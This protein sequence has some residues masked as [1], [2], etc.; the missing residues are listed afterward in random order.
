LHE[1]PTKDEFPVWIE[2]RGRRLR[3]EDIVE[4]VSLV[5]TSGYPTALLDV[6]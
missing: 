6:F 5:Q 4:T 3:F 1:T 2:S